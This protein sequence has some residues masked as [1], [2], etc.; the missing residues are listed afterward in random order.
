MV[1]EPATITLAAIAGKRKATYGVADDLSAAPRTTAVPLRPPLR[2]TLVALGL[3]LVG[4][5]PANSPA[6]APTAGHLIRHEPLPPSLAAGRSDRVIRARPDRAAASRLPDAIATASGRLSKPAPAKPGAPAPRYLPAPKAGTTPP[7]RI[8]ADAQTGRQGTLHY[9]VVFNP[10]VAPFKRD[11]VFDTVTAEGELA[12]SGVDLRPVR[13]RGD[14][15]RPGHELF[16]GHI[17]L[18]LRPGQKTPVPSVAPTSALLSAEATPRVPLTFWRDRAGNLS[19]SS[20]AAGQ[21][22]LRFVMDAPIRY[23]AAPLGDGRAGGGPRADDPWTPRL[24]APLQAQVQLLW[25]Q[26]GVAPRRSRKANLMALARWFRG[27]RP[28]AGPSATAAREQGNLLSS[29]VTGQVGVCRHR[30]L[31]FMV[32]AHSLQIPAQY[33]MNDAHAFV[34]VWVAGSDGRGAWQ[35]LDLGGGADELQVHA[36]EQKR[37]H[38]PLFRDPFPRPRAYAAQTGGGSPAGGPGSWAGAQRVKG[39]EAFRSAG[40]SGGDQR[41]AAQAEADQRAGKQGDGKQRDGERGGDGATSQP[42]T[43]QGTTAG[44]QRSG[45]G[46][47]PAERQAW[48]RARAQALAAPRR[49]PPTAKAAKAT[50]RRKRTPTHIEVRSAPQAWVGEPLRLAGRLAGP[51]K[52]VAKRELEVWLIQPRDPSKGQLIGTIQTGRGGA[53]KAAVAIPLDARLG[54]WDLV[55]RFAGTAKLAPSFSRN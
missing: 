7:A 51:P 23:F 36:A 21:V 42:R 34:E 31:G 6:Q 33:V 47:T 5:A 10:S 37:L 28:G 53:F 41:S 18:D 43:S 9:R 19:V 1:V 13:P 17:T 3:S 49:P 24:A 50:D 30:S 46:R 12:M 52:L 27:F 45:D 2:T 38:Q 54:V 15:A 39:A 8:K 14:R 25:A 32:L 35:R 48:L 40:G 26:V 55:V 4:L 16:W 20:T 29:L 44:G 22:D 11:L